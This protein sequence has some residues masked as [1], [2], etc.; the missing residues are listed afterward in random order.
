[1]ASTLASFSSLVSSFPVVGFSGSRRS[2]SRPAA[3]AAEFASGLAGCSSFSGSVSVGCAT[4]V[5][6]EVRGAFPSASVFSVAAS[7]VSRLGGAAFA[8]RSAALVQSVARSCG[9]L[10]AFPLG[11]AAPA[12]EPS[13]SFRGCGSGSWG[14]VALACGLGCP[15]LVVLPFGLEFPAGP[16]LASR[17]SSIGGGSG[18]TLWWAAPVAPSIS[19]TVLGV[20]G[21]LFS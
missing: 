7:E 10:V 12:V 13:R 2:G 1:M 5:D 14:S 18:Y 19:P 21:S 16:A 17:F 20:Q 9:V 6:A 8:A 3:F 4:G 15:V 11:A